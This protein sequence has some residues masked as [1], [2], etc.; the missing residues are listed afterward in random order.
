M[1]LGSTCPH[2]PRGR[3]CAAEKSFFSYFCC[4]SPAPS[5]LAA[6]GGLPGCVHVD[7]GYRLRPPLC[8]TLGPGEGTQDPFS[9][10]PVFVKN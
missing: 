7:S 5:L 9:P 2:H 3:I 6:L 1:Q 4:I 10:Y 8:E